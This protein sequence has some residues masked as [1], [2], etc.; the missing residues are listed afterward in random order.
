MA[1]FQSV[2][3]ASILSHLEWLSPIEDE[4]VEIISPVFSIRLLN[5]EWKSF[6]R[7][8]L[9]LHRDNGVS[10]YLILMPG[11]KELKLDLKSIGLEI[12]SQTR[13]YVQST[14]DQAKEEDF[15][16]ITYIG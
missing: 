5:L 2:K 3:A 9:I 7:V 15:L 1:N 14:N 6:R 16:L 12:T 11:E 4:A 8:T 10:S 13:F